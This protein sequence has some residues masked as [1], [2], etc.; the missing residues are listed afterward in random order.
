MLHII[1]SSLHSARTAQ[2]P[3]TVQ[4]TTPARPIHRGDRQPRIGRGRVSTQV[5]YEHFAWD[6]PVWWTYKL[7]QPRKQLI[8]PNYANDSPPL[9]HST[10]AIWLST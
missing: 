4:M 2:F 8:L 6:I 3:G 5:P 7:S 1:C 10:E 9:T